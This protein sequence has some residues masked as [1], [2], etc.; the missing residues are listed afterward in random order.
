MKCDAAVLQRTFPAVLS[1]KECLIAFARNTA[2]ASALDTA[3]ES[4]EGS[5]ADV[6]SLLKQALACIN[7]GG[8]P[9]LHQLVDL[10]QNSSQQ[11]ASHA[12]P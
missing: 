7:E 3:L 9:P 1:L 4:L 12:M 8:A 10:S 5:R 6:S 2:V 11:E